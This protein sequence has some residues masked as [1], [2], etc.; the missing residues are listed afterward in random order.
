MTPGW[1][2]QRPPP[3][4]LFKPS[5][6]ATAEKTQAVEIIPA[7]DFKDGRV[8]NLRQGK[9]DAS[10]TYSDDPVGMADRWV[11]Q[12]CSRLHLVDLDGAFA[13]DAPDAVNA[14]GDAVNADAIRAIARNHPDLKIQLGGGI[15]SEA[16]IEAW[17]E[18][19]VDYLIVGTR[20]V[21]E[22]EWACEMCRRFPGRIIVGLDAKDG[23]LAINGWKDVTDL[24]VT[25]LACQLQDEGAAAI[26]YT[27]IGRDGMMQGVNV[28]ATQALAND[29]KVP[30]IASGG[31]SGM[32]DVEALLRA[33]RQTSGSIAG[34]ITGR[35][36]Y[37]GSLDLARAIARAKDFA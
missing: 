6:T 4:A 8:V 36:I 37:E 17:L 11:A 1:V 25:D 29:V 35:A 32:G 12:G 14:K 24:H 16:I 22:P 30:I 5:F 23:K 34:V 18:A 20:A 33:G 31:V 9:L 2:R 13:A 27:D 26:V 7:I 21:Q 15:R 3:K 19:G 10:T 28:Q